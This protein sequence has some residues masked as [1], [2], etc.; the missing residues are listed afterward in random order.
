[1]AKAPFWLRGGKGKLAGSVLFKGERG[2]IV[3][4]NVTPHN[5]QTGGMMRQRALFATVTQAAKLMLPIIGLSF[6][7]IN[8][9]KL[10]RRKFVQLNTTYLGSI[11][12]NILTTGTNPRGL[13]FSGKGNAQLI[14]NPYI[15]SRGTLKLPN[16]GLAIINDGGTPNPQQVYT[17][18]IPLGQY[19]PL[20]LWDI[21]YGM[22]PGSQL[23]FPYITLAANPTSK[24]A[25]EITDDTGN[26]I[27]GIRYAQFHAPRIV[28][29]TED[30]DPVQITAETTDEQLEAYLAN[31]VVSEKTE[32]YALGFFCN[33]GVAAATAEGLP[34]S[35]EP[36]YEEM[37]V[38]AGYRYGAVG[39][40][41]S[42][43]DANGSWRYTNSQMV[44]FTVNNIKTAGGEFV[45]DYFGLKLE[46][47][48]NTYR[49]TS[50]TDK[51]YLQTGG[52][53]G[54]L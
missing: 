29:K 10:N 49:K 14:P 26:V 1:M 16:Q 33:R 13:R 23:T 3:R 42:E 32:Q 15:I 53:G 45:A 43:L 24:F 7:G 28:L 27:D 6:E 34:V 11:A 25:M 36:N 2:T 30:G 31:G 4:E 52:E 9:G 19:T 38:T 22:K 37:F 51:N 18:T 41:Y 50:T 44:N 5:P 47:A 12:R 54:N 35:I 8:E 48:I 46:N 21:L 39:L 40:I 17:V 20:Q